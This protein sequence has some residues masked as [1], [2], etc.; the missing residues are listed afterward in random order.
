MGTL[1]LLS[2]SDCVKLTQIPTAITG[3]ASSSV[4]SGC[5][6]WSDPFLYSISL[7]LLQYYSCV[8][9]WQRIDLHSKEFD[10]FKVQIYHISLFS[11]LFLGLEVLVQAF[12]ASVRQAPEVQKYRQGQL[13]PAGEALAMVS[14]PGPSCT[15]VTSLQECDAGCWIFPTM[16]AG[17]S[18]SYS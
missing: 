9:P 8:C 6:E 2:W 13:P 10:F 16:L 4:A 12:P 3:S 7:A 11:S 17:C 18:E 14:S 5:S 15:V 1:K